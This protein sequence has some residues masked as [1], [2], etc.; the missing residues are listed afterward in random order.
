MAVVKTITREKR[1]GELI[2]SSLI[3]RLQ[4]EYQVEKGTE[5]L[6]NKIKI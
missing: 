4:K 5:I 1:K 6:G 2:S 3:L